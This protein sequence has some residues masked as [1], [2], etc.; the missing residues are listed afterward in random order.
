MDDL[1]P[2][3]VRPTVRALAGVLGIGFMVCAVAL[4]VVFAPLIIRAE[5]E[6]GRGFAVMMTIVALIMLATIVPLFLSAAWT[7]VEP[8]WFADDDDSPAA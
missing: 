8:M 6:V 7:G 5:P 4:L 2:I 3:P 1:K